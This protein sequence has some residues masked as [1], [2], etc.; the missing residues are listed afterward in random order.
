MAKR[1]SAEGLDFKALHGR[2]VDGFS[3]AD[4][5]RYTGVWVALELY[6]PQTLP[7]RLIAAAGASASECIADLKAR[8]LDPEKFE[9]RPLVQPYVM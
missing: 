4:Q 1:R 3:L 2:P 6:S 9:Y 8:G 7:M 5:W